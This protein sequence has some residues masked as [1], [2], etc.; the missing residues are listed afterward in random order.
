MI[1]PEPEGDAIGEDE[2]D[3]LIEAADNEMLR[4]CR[5]LNSAALSPPDAPDSPLTR[6]ALLTDQHQA[7]IGSLDKIQV[8][9]SPRSSPA[10]PE[11][12]SLSRAREAPVGFLTPNR[13]RDTQSA[14]TPPED[15]LEAKFRDLQRRRE[16]DHWEMERLKL[17]VRE[18]S[19]QLQASRET[20]LESQALHAQL[21]QAH[22]ENKHLREEQLAKGPRYMLSPAPG[23][24][25]SPRPSLSPSHCPGA[26]ESVHQGT[27][28]IDE[29]RRLEF[30]SCSVQGTQVLRIMQHEHESVSTLD[31]P[32]FAWQ[33]FEELFSDLTSSYLSGHSNG[34]KSSRGF[35]VKKYSYFFNLRKNARGAFVKVNGESWEG[36]KSSGRKPSDG[37]RAQLFIPE[38]KWSEVSDLLAEVIGG[39]RE[40][41]IHL[42]TDEL[43]RL[44][45]ETLLH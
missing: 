19:G 25:T 42:I 22:W 33:R 10:Q 21:Q 28:Q 3:Q 44:V 5:S 8:S 23:V 15:G 1:Q 20:S 34:K 30:H 12:I 9:L 4:F 41:R 7:T 18:L 35:T 37:Q 16:E 26:A 29:E 27:C 6:L 43:Q 17:E 2:V 40:T 11:P 45:D 14:A 36:Q 32:Y 31:L 39:V 13:D 38:E 24:S